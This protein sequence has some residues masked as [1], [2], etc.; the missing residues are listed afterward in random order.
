[1]MALADARGRAAEQVRL[2]VGE[3]LGADSVLGRQ[4]LESYQQDRDAAGAGAGGDA[5][6]RPAGGGSGGRSGGAGRD[7]W[8]AWMVS[9]PVVRP[10]GWGN[11]RGPGRR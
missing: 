3:T 1:M 7:G 11:P 10:A 8:P 2:V 4:V 5:G 6:S 9:S